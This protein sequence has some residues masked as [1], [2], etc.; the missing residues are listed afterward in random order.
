MENQYDFTA[1]L[2]CGI[3][4]IVA[5]LG[6]ILANRGKDEEDSDI[7]YSTDP[8]AGEKIARQ[9]ARKWKPACKLIRIEGLVST[10]SERSD[11]SR[12]VTIGIWMYT[13]RMEK[14]FLIVHVEGNKVTMVG[15][16]FSDDPS[17]KEG[18]QQLAHHLTS[19]QEIDTS[20]IIGVRAAEKIAKKNG[21][22]LNLDA[23]PYV[24]KFRVFTY[25]NAL[26]WSLGYTINGK[27]FL[28]AAVGGELSYLSPSDMGRLY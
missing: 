4:A 7:V 22:M 25:N 20:K 8:I 15:N 27:A 17:A 19:F 5:I 9:S 14:A 1:L 3:L 13:Y 24:S 18:M 10:L 12:F 21:A 2:C 23:Y 28:I 6:I 26:V 16:E 11:K